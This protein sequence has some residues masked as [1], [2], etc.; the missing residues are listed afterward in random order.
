MTFFC[1]GPRDVQETICFALLAAKEPETRHTGPRHQAAKQ[2]V[3]LAFADKQEGSRLWEQSGLRELYLPL[4]K[5]SGM[6]PLD[7]GS[8]R[9]GGQTGI[10]K[11]P[12][13]EN[14]AGE[15]VDGRT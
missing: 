5:E 4:D 7:V 2:V 9:S 12:K 6:K 3:D 1:L 13:M 15:K 8:L 10:F 11:L 14:F